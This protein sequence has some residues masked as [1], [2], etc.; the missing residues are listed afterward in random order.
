MAQKIFE[1]DV[2]TAFELTI[3]D[4]D[5]VVNLSGATT[6]QIVFQPPLC[7]KITKTA[8]LK[9][10]GSDGV[11]RYVTQAGDLVGIGVWKCH[12][13]VVLPS[14]DWFSDEY[15]FRVYPRL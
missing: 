13:R 5:G 3:T 2:G 1:N 8:S 15:T 6:L 12:A 9:T 11:V 7:D 14:G 4:A 10:D